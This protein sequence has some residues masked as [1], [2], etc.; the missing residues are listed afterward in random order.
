MALGNMLAGIGGFTEGW[1]AMDELIKS[2]QSM[3]ARAEQIEGYEKGKALT[4]AQ[5]KVKEAMALDPTF[6]IDPDAP[7]AGSSTPPGT[8]VPESII[9]SFNPSETGV[10]HVA[11]KSERIA[12]Y[13]ELAKQLGLNPDAIVMT[14]DKEGLHKYS[15]DK[16]LSFGD[17]QMYTGPGGGM[18]NLALK[19]GINIRDPNTWKEQGKFALEQMAAHKGDTDWFGGQWHGPRNF[20][21]WA[22]NNFSNPDA[23]PPKGRY[24]SAPAAVAAP[25]PAAPSAL[26][27][28]YPGEVA[29][30]A[31]APAAGGGDFPGAT[32][33]LSAL[34][35]A[36]TVT[37]T[38]PAPP[39][40]PMTAPGLPTG[41]LPVPSLGP[42]V[43]KQPGQLPY[44][45]P[46]G[47]APPAQP[48]AA[49]RAAWIQ[50]RKQGGQDTIED[51]LAKQRAGAPRVTSGS[52]GGTPQM[53]GPGAGGNPYNTSLSP[54][55][56]AAFRAWV[57]NNKVKF[58]P[59]QDMT[60]Y[61]MRG[62]WAAQQQ[63]DRRAQT[64]YNP[65]ANEVHYPD[66]WK[67]P[68]HKTFS[69]DSQYA[70]P[71]APRWEG[72][73]L[74]SQDGTVLVDETAGNALGR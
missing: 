40:P 27:G 10:G 30:P 61:D 17:F 3:L 66:I 21:P 18:G 13:T 4:D 43:A 5:A 59:D 57:K 50:S 42:N 36:P 6:G 51:W 74:I 44:V 24:A 39:P 2:H 47:S 26:S 37:S 52:G 58:N 29:A 20:A 70:P 41:S 28:D 32:R 48:T 16:G 62:F 25:A 46:Y 54:A 64:Q 55:Q 9:S 72:G 33:A 14:I 15:G 22:V 38:A 49:E 73:R 12:Y 65:D 7:K 31:S 71:G 34:A 23:A 69:N 35:G 63:G 56:E 53:P 60:D 8:E 45:V 67:T 68:I 19:A 11:P 1:K